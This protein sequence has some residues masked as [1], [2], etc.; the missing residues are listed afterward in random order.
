MS[1]DLSTYTDVD[2][3]TLRAAVRTEQEARAAARRAPA[4]AAAVVDAVASG[5]TSDPITV[6]GLDG[7]TYTLVVQEQ[8]DPQGPPEWD[9]AAAYKVGAEV[10]EAGQRYA[11]TQDST[12]KQPSVSPTYWHAL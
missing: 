7:K 8:T 6:A 11:A 4:Q 5:R 2:L 3:E 10:T 1:V 9:A 12:G